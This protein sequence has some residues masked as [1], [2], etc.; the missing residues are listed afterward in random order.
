MMPK[1]LWAMV[2]RP[3]SVTRSVSRRTVGGRVSRSLRGL[4]RMV[5]CVLGDLKVGVK[6]W[7]KLLVCESPLADLT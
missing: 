1:L 3:F 4:A 7:I 2:S 6:I 5:V